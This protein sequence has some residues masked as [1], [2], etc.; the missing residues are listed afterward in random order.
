MNSSRNRKRVDQLRAIALPSVLRVWGAVLDRHDKGKWHTARG[1][2]S[3]N[4]AK[5]I[6][7]NQAEGGGGAID[8]VIHLK[9]CGF[10]EALDWLEHHFPQRR[11]DDLAPSAPSSTLSLPAPDPLQLGRVK[12]YL[13]TQRAIPALLIESL[14][15]TGT[16]YADRRANAVFLL[17]DLEGSAVGAELRGTTSRQWRGMAPG[18]RKNLG[19][20]SIPAG[21]LGVDQP[22]IILCESAIDAISAFALHPQH[23]CLS[24]AGARPDPAWLGP[25]I[26][27]GARVHCGFDADETGERMAQA[28]IGFHPSVIRLRP[29]RHDWN[30]LLISPQ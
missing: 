20:F 21:L 25:L 14:I 28:M 30:D 5:F 19:F 23:R 7:W 18:S 9:D 11:G 6:N 4:G 17:R 15:Q 29:P 2:L 16:L 10:K 24:S 27:K 12:D 3:V 26:Q 13:T 22:P 8:L 1:T